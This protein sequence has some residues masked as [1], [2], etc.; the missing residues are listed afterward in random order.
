MD[1]GTFIVV[2]LSILSATLICCLPIVLVFW[3]VARKRGGHK[4]NG[5]EEARLRDIWDGLQKMEQRLQNIE[6]IVAPRRRDD[7][8]ETSGS[9]HYTNDY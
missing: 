8:R 4:R 6:T 3:A 9:T 2:V 7:S 5:D 1:G